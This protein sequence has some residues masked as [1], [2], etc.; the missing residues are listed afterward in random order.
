MSLGRH[1]S[2]ILNISDTSPSSTSIIS[3]TPL[4]D[5]SWKQTNSNSSSVFSIMVFTET[6]YFCPSKH[7]IRAMSLLIIVPRDALS[8]N[9]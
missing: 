3:Q 8:N 2:D 7:R 1:F 9:P 4:A 6:S 5:W